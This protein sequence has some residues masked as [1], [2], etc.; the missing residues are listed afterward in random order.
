MFENA[1]IED[2][3]RIIAIHIPMKFKRRGGRKQVILPPGAEPDETPVTPLQRAL[4]RAFH[5]QKLLDSGK[6]CSIGDISKSTGVD[7][8]FIAKTLRLTLLAPDIIEAILNNREPEAVTIPLLYKAIPLLWD[9]Q[10]KLYGFAH[11]R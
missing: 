4:A 5:W 9:E 7:K 8:S 1:R 10:R 2:G 11:A 3:G 6:A